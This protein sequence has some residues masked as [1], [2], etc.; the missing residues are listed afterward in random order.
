[1]NVSHYNNLINKDLEGICKN[2]ND[3]ILGWW[4]NGCSLFLF[5]S[6]YRNLPFI[7]LKFLIEKN[8]FHEHGGKKNQQFRG[9]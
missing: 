6:C 1:M 2:T 9:I 4:V 3:I 5:A 7:I 8:V